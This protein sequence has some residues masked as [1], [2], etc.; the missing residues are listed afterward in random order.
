MIKTLRIICDTLIF[1]AG[2]VFLI[3]GNFETGFLCFIF[4]ELVRIREILEQHKGGV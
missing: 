4:I 2:M 3:S 1:I